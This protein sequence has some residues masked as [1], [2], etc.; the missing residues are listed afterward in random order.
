MSHI[1]QHLQTD[2]DARTSQARSRHAASSGKHVHVDWET[3]PTSTGIC[4][5]SVVSFGSNCAVAPVIMDYRS[6]KMQKRNVNGSFAG[7]RLNAAHVVG[8]LLEC[9]FKC[10]YSP[11][12]TQ[13]P[14]IA[15][16]ISSTD[17]PER[18]FFN[19]V[20]VPGARAPSSV[21]IAA[22]MED[23]ELALKIFRSV[24]DRLQGRPLY[25][26]IHTVDSPCGVS[27]FSGSHDL[28]VS[29]FPG[30]GSRLKPGIYSVELKCREIQEK[31]PRTF[32]WQDTLQTEALP[33]F[34]AEATRDGNALRGRLLILVE[35]SKPCHTGPFDVHGALFDADRMGWQ[36]VF[37]WSGFKRET[38]S[39]SRLPLPVPKALPAPRP[40]PTP[41]RSRAAGWG[42]VASTLPSLNGWVLLCRFL[43]HPMINKPANQTMRYLT[44][45][46]PCRWRSST[47]GKPRKGMDWKYMKVPGRGG[48]HGNGAVH[49]HVD[50][51]QHVFLA[52]LGPRAAS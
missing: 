2:Q 7:N 37:G 10:V 49:C 14:K 39:P 9:A 43:K 22:H 44:G 25:C 3:L 34:T 26:Q 30:L 19:D 5:I 20:L 16:E 32:K 15:T 45:D 11:A 46:L 35:M 33:L 47:G 38:S 27:T 50:F 1:K 24:L 31:Q 4:Q 41:R 28:L 40:A 17:L 21:N 6:V 13:L 48:G 36:D 18:L 8:K 29:P 51:L 42:E 52:Q 23:K 12:R